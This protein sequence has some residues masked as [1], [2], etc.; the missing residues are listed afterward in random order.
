MK[1]QWIEEV[2]Q[3]KPQ[4]PRFT[5]QKVPSKT[6]VVIPTLNKALG[7]KFVKRHKHLKVTFVLSQGGF[8]RKA[9]YSKVPVRKSETP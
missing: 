6:S 2:R 9:Q 8:V 4:G 1:R 5:E 7:S 3:K